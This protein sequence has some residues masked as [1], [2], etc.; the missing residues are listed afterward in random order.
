MSKFEILRDICQF[1]G[2]DMYSYSGRA[3]YGKQCPA[4]NTD[5]LLRGIAELLE[6][7]IEADQTIDDED[8]KLVPQL[9][10]IIRSAR[11]DNMGL[12]YVVYFPGIE[13]EGVAV[14]EDESEEEKS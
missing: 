8:K 14:D 9:A 3:M 7:A 12:D 4:F 1:G 10:S 13:W 2:L 11:T 6:A 5:T